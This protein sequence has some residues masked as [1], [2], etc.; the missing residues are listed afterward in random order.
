MSEDRNFLGTGWAFPPSFERRTKRAATVSTEE[1]IHESLRILLGTAP[2]ERVMHP[3]Y[4]CGL[5]IM[6]F[7]S[8]NE[9]T[10]TEIKDIVQ[11]AILHFE[12]RITLEDIYVDA[13]SADEGILKIGLEYT[14]RTTNTRMNVVFPFYL[15]E[16][17]SLG[18]GQ[19]VS[20]GSAQA[21]GNP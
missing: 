18:P 2:G 21:A 19:R 3:S 17:T 6:V 14:V 5:K 15:H 12:V 16:G 4:G 9:S 10:I 8:I 13:T 11:K 7:E 1:D 20:A